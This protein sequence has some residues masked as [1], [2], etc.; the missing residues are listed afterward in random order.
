[1]KMELALVLAEAAGRRLGAIRQLRWEDVDFEAS[2]VMWWADSDKKGLMWI[3]PLP[4]ELLAELAGFRRTLGAIAGWVFWAPPGLVDTG[5][6]LLTRG[7]AA[8]TAR[9]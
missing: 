5:F 9:G 8:R 1:M 7:V 6:T 4:G 3:V 2:E